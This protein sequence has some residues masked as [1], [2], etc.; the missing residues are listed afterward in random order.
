MPN[1]TSLCASIE[2]C[3]YIRYLVWREASALSQQVFCHL[4]GWQNFNVIESSNERRI[5][6]RYASVVRIHCPDYHEVLWDREATVPEKGRMKSSPR[7]GLSMYVSNSPK[8]L[9]GSPRLI[10]SIVKTTSRFS[11]LEVPG[12]TAGKHESLVDDLKSRLRVLIRPVTF[13]EVLISV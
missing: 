9:A 12:T 6:L 13:N 10:S 1:G 5:D 11:S 3:S 7:Y 4:A 8:T 2:P